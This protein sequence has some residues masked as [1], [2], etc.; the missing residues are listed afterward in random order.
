MGGRLWAALGAAPIV[1][2]AVGALVPLVAQ[3]GAPAGE[4]RAYGGGLGAT[5]YSDLSEIDATNVGDLEIAWRWSARNQGARPEI[6]N[7]TTPLMVNGVL[8]ATAGSRRNVSAIDAGTGETLWMWRMDEGVRGMNAPRRN[9]G[10]GV[11]YW[12]DGA[13]DERVYVVTPGYHLVALDARTGRPVP[14]FGQDGVV[15]LKRGLGR[16]VDP[17]N[18]IIGSSSPPV[19]ARGVVVVGAALEIGS[20][21]PSPENVPGH[22][23]GFDVKTGEQRWIFHTIPEPGEFGS[24]TWEGDSWS[25][26]GNAAVWAPFSV[27]PELGYVYL[28]VE[29]ATHDYYGGHRLGDN[30]FATSLVAL[31]IETGERVWHYQLVHH[32]IWDRDVPT[33]PILVDIE[34]EGQPIRAVVQLTK[35]AFAYVFDR[36]TGEPVWP[37]EERPVPPSSVEGERAAPTQPFPAKPAAYDRQGVT[38]DDLID[39]TPELRAEA[40]ELVSKWRLGPLY[41]P[42]GLIEG[43]GGVGGTLM[44]PG[45]LGGTNWEGG[46][47]DPETGVL[48]VGSHTSPSIV[49]LVH[50]PEASEADYVL[51]GASARGPQRLPLIK[52]PYGRITAIDLNTGDHLWMMPNGD[53]PQWIEEHPALEGVEIGRTGKPTRA[54]ILVTKTLV[55]AGEGFGGGPTLWAYDKATGEIL[56]AIDLPSSQSGLPM[57]YLHEGRQYV[58]FSVGGQGHPAELIALALPRN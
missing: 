27:D 57:T 21:P 44:L 49:G 9:S 17:V 11:A 2:V 15:D 25:Y 1:M 54:G 32:D 47:F 10:R 24:E 29:D 41:T 52:P 34:V 14:S 51:A 13:G 46:A 37:I 40:E 58:V 16:P 31:D 39:F 19:I 26:T 30:L 22:V 5:R 48:Y 38:L 23:R 33:A 12:T 53:T 55:L 35:Q 56:G 6:K 18:G 43:D 28:P 50:D 8:Y 42:P 36:V 45:I 3:Q 4:W 7:S 20:R